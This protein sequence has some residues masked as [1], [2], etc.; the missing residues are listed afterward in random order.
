MKS[1]INSLAMALI[2]RGLL[3]PS[4]AME[5]AEQWVADNADL[6]GGPP[7]RV[8]ATRSAPASAPPF[9]VVAE[10]RDFVHGTYVPIV[11]EDGLTDKQRSAVGKQGL[12]QNCQQPKDDHLPGCAVASGENARAVTVSRL[13]PVQ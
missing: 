12:C 6:F 9:E 5:F 10:S 8:P 1:L 13:A 3:A 11:G 2:I 4:A 7:A